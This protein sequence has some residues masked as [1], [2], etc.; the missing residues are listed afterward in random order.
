MLIQT[1]PK[2]EKL[3]IMRIKILH[4]NFIM[5]RTIKIIF[6]INKSNAA[7]CK[8]IIQHDRVVYIVR[9]QIYSH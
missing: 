6:K 3:D 1:I 8:R 9:M 5:S 2:K 4:A 7:V